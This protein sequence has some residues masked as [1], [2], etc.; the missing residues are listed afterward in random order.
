[1]R[2]AKGAPARYNSASVSASRWLPRLY[3]AVVLVTIVPIWCVRYLPTAENIRTELGRML[4]LVALGD[5]PKAGAQGLEQDG[6]E[7]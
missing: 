1:M 7:V 3:I 4:R 2:V 6:H 5:D